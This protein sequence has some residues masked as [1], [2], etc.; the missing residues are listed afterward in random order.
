[1]GTLEDDL[2]IRALHLLGAHVLHELEG[3]DQW[4]VTYLQKY[5]ESPQDSSSRRLYP[6]YQ[7]AVDR[8]LQ[9]Q[10]A[11]S[12]LAALERHA[13]NYPSLLGLAQV[14]RARYNEEQFVAFARFRLTECLRWEVKHSDPLRR[15]LESW[16]SKAGGELVTA[17]ES[18]EAAEHQRGQYAKD[19]K[20][21]LEAA[22]VNPDLPRLCCLSALPIE[23]LADTTARLL[24][25]T[26][27]AHDTTRYRTECAQRRQEAVLRV[28][29]RTGV[30][31]RLGLWCEERAVAHPPLGL[32]DV[33]KQL[34]DLVLSELQ[35]ELT[36]LGLGGVG[37]EGLLKE[38]SVSNA[39]LVQ[40]GMLWN[41]H[42]PQYVLRLKQNKQKPKDTKLSDE[43]AFRTLLEI[44]VATARSDVLA[45]LLARKG[46]ER[47]ILKAV[48]E[49]L[50]S[51]ME[52]VVRATAHIR[53]SLGVD[54]AK[55]ILGI[56]PGDEDDAPNI[57][58]ST[59]WSMATKILRDRLAAQ[60]AVQ[61]SKF[62]QAIDCI[63]LRALAK[64]EHGLKRLGEVANGASEAAIALAEKVLSLRER[65]VQGRVATVAGKREDDDL[66]L[67]AFR[68]VY[69]Q[70]RAAQK[71]LLQRAAQFTEEG[72]ND[73]LSLPAKVFEEGNEVVVD[74]F[75]EQLPGV[76]VGR[77]D[78]GGVALYSVHF[79]GGGEEHEIPSRWIRPAEK[80]AAP[81]PL[82]PK[83]LQLPLL[84]PTRELSGHSVEQHSRSALHTSGNSAFMPISS[85]RS[86]SDGFSLPQPVATRS[87]LRGGIPIM[88]REDELPLPSS[89][90]SAA[91]TLA[92]FTPL[93]KGVFSQ[94]SHSQVGDEE[95]EEE[96]GEDESDDQVGMDGVLVEECEA[97]EVEEGHTVVVEEE[98]VA[99]VVEEVTVGE[100]GGCGSSALEEGDGR[101]V[102]VGGSE[103]EE[104]VV[105]DDAVDGMGLGAVL[106]AVDTDEH[107]TEPIEVEEQSLS[108]A[109]VE[110]VG[111]KAGRSKAAKEIPRMDEPAMVVDE[112]HPGPEEQA[113]VVEE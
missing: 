19:C 94:S 91:S 38:G 7:E 23:P 26:A 89:P 110:V 76:V 99:T 98:P 107:S 42:L 13:P 74:W 100:E 24:Q 52:S 21:A 32:A 29:A 92:S 55:H 6:V 49:H 85:N 78:S 95:E 48:E 88:E 82:R 93:D 58:H 53:S 22:K 2:E 12:V 16:F 72:L 112:H 81:V 30:C 97:A 66:W 87:V 105:V 68:D 75:G 43:T 69:C 54:F 70:E 15:H 102:G 11:R 39:S 101:T 90:K 17:I 106:V 79:H 10:N 71:A 67:C 5:L 77:C 25:M 63:I 36:K 28:V 109:P 18:V 103:G 45:V 33:Q 1:M 84:R 56:N 50:E 27:A 104:P 57:R 46:E 86:R 14:L 113:V 4:R 61:P 62:V 31:E 41:E 20:A 73:I 83:T 37:T 59:L 96:E 3:W 111:G 64:D 9:R 34:K 8:A 108:P 60:Q 80:E 40:K 65:R 47:K 35:K 44:L 51:Y